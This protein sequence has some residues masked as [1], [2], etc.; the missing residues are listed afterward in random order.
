MAPFRSNID[1]LLVQ[2]ESTTEWVNKT[3]IIFTP[4]PDPEGRKKYTD[5]ISDHAPVWASFRTDVDDDP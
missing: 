1:H 5:F 4:P 3:T 2:L